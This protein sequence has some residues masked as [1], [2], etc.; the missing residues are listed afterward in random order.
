MLEYEMTGKVPLE[1]S[2]NG[3]TTGSSSLQAVHAGSH[4]AYHLCDSGDDGDEDGD[5]SDSD[6][7][8]DDDKMTRT[9]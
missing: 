9:R 4:K 8:G 7:D 3:A 2:T 6:E 1:R 5:D